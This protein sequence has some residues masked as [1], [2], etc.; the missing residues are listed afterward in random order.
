MQGR[1]GPD[2][3]T[4]AHRQCQQGMLQPG[5]SLSWQ[6]SGWADQG[7]QTLSLSGCVLPWRVEFHPR[8]FPSPPF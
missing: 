4:Q 7:T 2:R 8:R 3:T 5:Q 6:D 1:N